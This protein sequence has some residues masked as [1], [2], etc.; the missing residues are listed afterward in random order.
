MSSPT[1][2]PG[3]YV[4]NG[5]LWSNTGFFP[6][7][8]GYT[9]ENPGLS[10]NYYAYDRVIMMPTPGRNLANGYGAFIYQG[11]Q[12]WRADGAPTPGWAVV[13][14][15]TN[16]DTALG[17]GI[18]TGLYDFF[19][20]D[21]KYYV[22]GFYKATGNAIGVVVL[23]VLAGTWS[24]FTT[25][26]SVAVTAMT[27]PVAYRGKLYLSAE[28]LMCTF[29]PE[30]NVVE[31]IPRP[32]K[33]N[34]PRDTFF[35]LGRRLFLVGL[36]LGSLQMW[37]GPNWASPTTLGSFGLAP[38]GTFAVAKSATN[39][40]VLWP[41]TSGFTLN[42]YRVEATETLYSALTVT[43]VSHTFA[44]TNQF[45]T[46]AAVNVISDSDTA[47]GLDTQHRLY[48]HRGNNGV[49]PATVPFLIPM[50]SAP[51][52]TTGGVGA[53]VNN[54][55]TPG[56]VSYSSGFGLGPE[57][58][59]YNRKILPYLVAP[60]ETVNPGAVRLSYY[61]FDV[62]STFLSS[63]VY[64]RARGAGPSNGDGSRLPQNSGTPIGFSGPTGALN[65][66]QKRID[67][68]TSSP[69]GTAS[70]IIWDRVADLGLDFPGDVYIDLLL[71]E[72]ANMPAP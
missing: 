41:Q 57:I 13:H 51:L 49:N 47:P 31:E 11:N 62:A 44:S 34:D 68:V 3:T 24:S 18:H 35:V 15:T 64:Y 7:L 54:P 21:G 65:S 4:N 19:G 40:L 17:Y 55:A 72:A 29:D 56:G 12:I 33:T 46:T 63:R 27:V 37:E 25:S 9:Q 59:N 39:V 52:A 26:V 45:S 36:N 32:T 53:I 60:D 10:N 8:S 16:Q 23:D 69:S 20:R 2:T 70:A 48:F 28:G 22:A 42:I 14:T 38:G 50:I 6:T 71:T 67:N 58:I 61:A 30:Q 5:T 66:G 43:N 1:V